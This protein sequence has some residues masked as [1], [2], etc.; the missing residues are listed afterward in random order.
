MFFYYSVERML[1]IK[2]KVVILHS[3]T[4]HTLENGLIFKSI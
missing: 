3:D 2:L 1:N 4:P